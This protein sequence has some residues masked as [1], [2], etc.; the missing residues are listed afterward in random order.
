M[1]FEGQDGNTGTFRSPGGFEFGI[2][3]FVY[4]P[5]IPSAITWF[6]DNTAIVADQYGRRIKGVQMPDGSAIIF[7]DCPPDASREGEII[8]RPQFATHAQVIAALTAE[9]IDWLGYE[10]RYRARDNTDKLRSG[11]SFKEAHA[12]QAKLIQEGIRFVLLGRTISCAGWPQL[13]YEDLKK[14]PELP[15]T[16]LEELRKIRDTQLRR[17]AMRIRRE[18]DESRAKEM[19]ASEGE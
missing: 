11:M 1:P 19:Q 7:A 12:L 4:G 15:P 6:L 3:G 17:D 10:V 9:R 16:P 13:K 5:P 18:V 2:Q 14:I 8:P